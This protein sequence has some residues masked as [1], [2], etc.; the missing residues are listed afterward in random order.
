M[1]T[2]MPWNASAATWNGETAATAI[3]AA[4]A[5]IIFLIAIREALR[6]WKWRT[7]VLD[8]LV[9]PR[10]AATARGEAALLAV[11]YVILVV[12]STWMLQSATQDVIGQLQTATAETERP[13]DD[14][15][16]QP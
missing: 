15:S 4:A 9:A 14:G 3:V 12:A 16:Q 1:P 13:D 5:A 10:V 7:D 8:G 2:V 6:L 11:V